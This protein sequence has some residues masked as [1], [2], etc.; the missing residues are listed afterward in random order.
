MHWLADRT[1]SFFTDNFPPWQAIAMGGPVGIAWSFAC[2]RFSG[3]LKTRR[4]W[5]TGYTRKTFHFLIFASVVAIERVW[6][7]PIVCLFGSELG[8][9]GGGARGVGSGHCGRGGR[10]ARAALHALVG[11]D[12]PVFGRC[13][14]RGG[15]HFAPRLGQ[16]HAPAR[17]LAAGLGRS[18]VG[19]VLARR[20]GCE[21]PPYRVADLPPR[22]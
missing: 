2:L 7:T 13:L 5:Q 20:R 9:L 21:Q 19:C 4:R 15:G 1:L 3:H 12:D 6:G 22:N 8:G 11:P 18:P 17:P 16:R 10:L 14:R